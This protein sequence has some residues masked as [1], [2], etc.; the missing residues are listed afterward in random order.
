MRKGIVWGLLCLLVISICFGCKIFRSAYKDGILV[1]RK[2]QENKVRELANSSKDIIEFAYKTYVGPFEEHSSIHVRAKASG[3]QNSYNFGFFLETDIF[4]IFCSEK[5]GKLYQWGLGGYELRGRVNAKMFT[6]ERNGDVDSILLYESKAIRSEANPYLLEARFGT[7]AYF[8]EYISK[9][10]LHGFMSSNGVITFPSSR[11]YHPSI[12]YQ[13]IS[14]RYTV[15]LYLK[16]NEKTPIDVNIH[17]SYVLINGTQYDLKF[18]SSD[19]RNVSKL[20]L[21][22]GQEIDENINFKIPGLTKIDLDSMKNIIFQ[23][24]SIRCANF[25]QINYYDHHKRAAKY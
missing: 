14:D 15:R 5:N 16:N 11:I 25:K 7:K 20:H 8:Q 4:K 2:I 13:L 21:N 12:P 6:C 18:D 17:N 3:S 1:D 22:P 23:L 10:Q 9:N 24:D 19:N